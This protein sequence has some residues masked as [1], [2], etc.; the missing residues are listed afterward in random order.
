MQG[1]FRIFANEYIGPVPAADTLIIVVPKIS[2]AD[3]STCL[4]KGAVRRCSESSFAVYIIYFKVL[5][6]SVFL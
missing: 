1:T 2:L 5:I 3:S 4:T 6:E